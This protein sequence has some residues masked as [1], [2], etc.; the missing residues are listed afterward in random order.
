M[1]D[2]STELCA[3]MEQ[4]QPLLE[5]INEDERLLLGDLHR[6]I[7]EA[8]M[9]QKILCPIESCVKDLHF[10][11]DSRSCSGLA[12][13]PASYTQ[14][15]FAQEKQSERLGTRLQNMYITAIHRPWRKLRGGICRYYVIKHFGCESL[16]WVTDRHN[17]CYRC[18]GKHRASSCRFRESRCLSAKT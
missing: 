1:A 13:H 6:P 4:L 16:N 7:H 5:G 10:F 14:Q 9:L 8:Y 2:T 12:R 17:D 3:G 11:D 18:R 15:Y